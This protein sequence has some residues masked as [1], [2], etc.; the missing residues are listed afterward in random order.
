MLLPT[1][2]CAF[3]LQV[4]EAADEVRPLFAEID[5]MVHANI[6]RVQQVRTSSAC[7]A[8]CMHYACATACKHQADAAGKCWCNAAE[9][10]GLFCMADA[11]LQHYMPELSQSLCLTLPLLFCA[12]QAMRRHRIGPHHFAGS[13]GAPGLCT[14][15][16]CGAGSMNACP[17]LARYP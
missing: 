12:P 5:R 16:L 17:R 6:K 15:S 11:A 4:W 2:A 1:E 13:T 8:V 7:R 3:C 14:A 10:G 9:S